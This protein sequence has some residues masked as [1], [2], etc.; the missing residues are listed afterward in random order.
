MFSQIKVLSLSLVMLVGLQGCVW[1]D[2]PSDLRAFIREKLSAPGGK[3]DPLPELL[4]YESYVYKGSSQRDPF[5]A[6]VPLVV[7]EEDVDS[8]QSSIQPDFNR[9]KVYLEEFPV[10]QLVMV[11]TISSPID[12]QLVALVRDTNAEVHQIRIDSRMGL[13]HG[14]VVS[15]NERGIELE[16]IVANG[17]GGW[18]SRS[19]T[20]KLPGLE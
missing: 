3:V 13:D 8:T 15:L 1:V 17:R 5:V 2:D 6:L 11:G 9:I 14:I 18:M 12:G 7:T 19:R 16:E 10:D 4:I 20:I